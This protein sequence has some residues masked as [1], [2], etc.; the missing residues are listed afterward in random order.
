M[1]DIHTLIANLRRPRLLV[2]AAR[3]GLDD[4]K[5]ERVLLRLLQVDVLPRSG[6]AIM[7][8]MGVE[9]ELND[10][11]IA[12]SAT[13]TIADHIETLTAIMGEAEIL[14]ATHRPK[15]DQLT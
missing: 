14:Q 12:K 8:L 4:Y 5:R 10:Q 9:A 11:R 6:D 2:R 7:Q 15:A 13:Y 1:L 3:F